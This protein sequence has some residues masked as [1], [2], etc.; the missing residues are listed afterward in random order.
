MKCKLEYLNWINRIIIHIKQC[1]TFL[2][3]ERLQWPFRKNQSNLLV[4]CTFYRV[5]EL[6]EPARIRIVRKIEHHCIYKQ[7]LTCD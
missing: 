7:Y 5:S 3:G 2:H 4:L 1:L 6:I